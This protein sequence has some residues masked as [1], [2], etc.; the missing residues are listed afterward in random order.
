MVRTKSASPNE[1]HKYS[2]L[3]ALSWDRTSVASAFCEFCGFC[4]KILFRVSP[5][6]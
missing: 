2:I 6:E 5:I 3:A 4:V 1:T